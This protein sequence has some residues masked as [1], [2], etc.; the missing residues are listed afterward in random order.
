MRIQICRG[1][2]AAMTQP[3][4]NFDQGHSCCDQ[5]ICAAMT[6]I[7]KADFSQIIL[8]QN[9][10]KMLRQIIWFKQVSLLI[11]TDIRIIIWFAIFKTFFKFYTQSMCQRIHQRK[12][13]KTGISFELI[14]GND[15]IMAINRSEADGMI[16]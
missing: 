3:L 9:Q 1:G 4:L 10:L 2:Y 8:L 14:L 7:M 6:Q 5:K 11:N 15:L 13:T 16:Y 12:C